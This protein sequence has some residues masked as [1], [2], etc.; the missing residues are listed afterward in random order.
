MQRH[1]RK[2]V[3][4]SVEEIPFWRDRG[5]WAL[6]G[7]ALAFRLLYI[8]DYRGSEFFG[9]LYGDPEI[10]HQRAIEIL[11]GQFFG[12]SVSFHSSPLYP[13][14]LALIYAV[15]GVHVPAVFVFQAGI[16]AIDVVLVATC[17]QLLLGRRGFWLAGVT[18]ACWP[19][20]AY[21]DAELF[22]IALVLLGAHVL[23]YRLLQGRG[24]VLAGLGLG[25][26]VMGKPNTL[27]F[28]PVWFLWKWRQLRSRTAT[29]RALAPLALGVV[30]VVAPFTLRNWIVGRDLVLTSSNGGINLYIGNNEEARGT[31]RVPARMESDLFGSSKRIAE[32]DRGRSFKPSEVSAYWASKAWRWVSTHPGEALVLQGRKLL[33]LVNRIEVSN[34][35]D[36]NFLERD[37][38]LL[39]YTPFRFGWWMPFAFWGL[40]LAVARVRRPTGAAD[41]LWAIP[42]L[43]VATYSVSLLPF[44]VTAR[45]RLPMVPMLLVFSALG[46]LDLWDRAAARRR[47]LAIGLVVVASGFVLTHLPLTRTEWFFPFQYQILGSAAR[48]RGDIEQAVRHFQEAVRL[49]PGSVLAH[50]NLGACLGRLGRK[51]EATRE[52]EAA[53]RIDPNFPAAW[54][55]LARVRRLDGD[56]DG[57]RE[58]LERALVIDPGFLDARSDLVRLLAERGEFVRALEESDRVLAAAPDD[59]DVLW[60]RALLLGQHLHRTG[61][62]IATLDRLEAVAGATAESRAYR[63]ALLAVPR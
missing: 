25:L 17:A 32:Q 53:L 18:L 4:K 56:H 36:P 7:L 58:C 60:N 6:F 52:Y 8:L 14:V 10:Y 5:I 45:Y 12:T 37:V 31:F 9:L 47:D 27:L 50:N 40:G 59:R 28:L 41:R 49:A 48:D 21:Y 2:R 61:E 62:A 43:W 15:A 39:R 51:D 23:I 44:F 42:L 29:V 33:L 16:G 19:I 1:E 3:P 55:N 22:E 35:F 24:G 38:A 30:I 57:E 34:H 63:A 20:L 11:K 46:L 54:R 13:Y 26:A